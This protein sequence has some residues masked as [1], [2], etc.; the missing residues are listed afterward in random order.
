MQKTILTIAGFS[1]MAAVIV[2]AFGAHKLE[3]ILVANNTLDTFQTASEYHFYH[4]FLLIALGILSRRIPK[5]YT[6]FSFIST[7]A[8][9]IV[10]SGS[11]YIYSL[12]GL[13]TL[14]M[15]TPIG[16]LFLILGWIGFIVAVIFKK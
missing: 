12:L 16:G 10:F 2:G 15:I 8:G 1:G 9:M 3:P 11:L 5:R 14:A 6:Q 4:T 7:L 13:K